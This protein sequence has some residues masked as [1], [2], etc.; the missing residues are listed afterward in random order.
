MTLF[1]RDLPSRVENLERALAEGK[2]LEGA[3]MLHSLR[4]VLGTLGALEAE[5]LAGKMEQRLRDGR[6]QP[7]QVLDG[8]FREALRQFLSALD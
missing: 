8:P 3:S 6:M 7:N 4:G 1:R 5:G 2:Y